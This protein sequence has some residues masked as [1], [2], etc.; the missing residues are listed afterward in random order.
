MFLVCIVF[1]G[2]SAKSNELVGAWTGSR[3]LGGVTLIVHSTG[4]VSIKLVALRTSQFEGELKMV[5]ETVGEIINTVPEMSESLTL[6]V[7]GEN[8]VTLTIT[9]GAKTGNMPLTRIPVEAALK[10]FN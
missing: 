8:S 10:E 4:S 6:T 3:G 7:L 2:C 1:F 5:S 9:E